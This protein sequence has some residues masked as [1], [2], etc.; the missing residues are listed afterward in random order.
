MLCASENSRCVLSENSKPNPYPTI[1][2]TANA[3]LSFWVNAAP[4][5]K[6]ALAIAEGLTSAIVAKKSKAASSRAVARL[7]S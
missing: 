1:S 4:D 3:T 7:Y 2:S 5:T 6:S